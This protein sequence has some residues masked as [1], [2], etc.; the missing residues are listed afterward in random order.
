MTAYPDWL[1]IWAEAIK[2]LGPAVVASAAT[3]L[4]SYLL[5]RNQLKTKIAELK[6]QSE[7][8]ARE[9]L[10]GAYQKK[11]DRINK[12]AGRAA[13]ELGKIG[14]LLNSENDENALSE[15]LKILLFL[16]KALKSGILEAVEELEAEVKILELSTKASD[17]IIAIRN[18]V[19]AELQGAISITQVQEIYFKWVNAINLFYS[20]SADI[21]TQ[22]AERLFGDLLPA[23]RL[24]K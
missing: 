10:F 11:I 18:G 1:S 16:M 21:L 9:L 22:K 19:S 14:A 6:G 20:V 15:A 24:R 23:P 8:R 13:R 17:K 4:G 3:L 12:N 2:T 5:F 7:L